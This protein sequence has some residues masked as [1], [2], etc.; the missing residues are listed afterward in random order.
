VPAQRVTNRRVQEIQYGIG[1]IA[2]IARVGDDNLRPNCRQPAGEGLSCRANRGSQ[3]F[4][5][6]ADRWTTLDNISLHNRLSTRG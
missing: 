1:Q 4:Y 5:H 2:E 3:P 6:S